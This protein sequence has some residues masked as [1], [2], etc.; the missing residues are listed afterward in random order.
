MD[1]LTPKLGTP[2]L[3]SSCQQQLAQVQPD[4]REASERADTRA[5]WVRL[6]VTVK[7]L[8]SRFVFI[9]TGQNK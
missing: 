8:H 9:S 7:V 3:V 1:D 4:E 5:H 2:A 6:P